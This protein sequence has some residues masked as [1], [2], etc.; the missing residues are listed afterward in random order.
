MLSKKK[1]LTR[2]LELTLLA[3]TA[4][5]NAVSL[6]DLTVESRPGEPMMGTL[7]IRDIDFTVSPLLVR[8]AAP[9]TYLRA[10]LNWPTQVRD[11]R[12]ARD[13]SQSALRIKV[14]GK[15]PMEASSFPLLI[16]MNAGGK[17]SVTNYQIVQKNG[18][19]EVLGWKTIALDNPKTETPFVLTPEVAPAPEAIT[20]QD[21]AKASALATT[22]TPPKVTPSAPED[23]PA[24]ATSTKRYT[25]VFSQKAKNEA[26]VAGKVAEAKAQ[27][28]KTVSKQPK[29]RSAPQIVRDYVALN[30]FDA[31][32]P[33]HVQNNMTLWSVAKLYWPSYRGATLEQL[34]LAFRDRNP[35]AFE[36][37]DP[38]LLNAGSTLT[39]PTVDEVFAIDAMTAFRS[40]HGEN[41]PVPPSTQNL[42]D[43]QKISNTLASTVAD[44]QDRERTDGGAQEAVDQAG[45]EALRNGERA[46]AQ[47]EATLNE[48]V[49][50]AQVVTPEVSAEA[51]DKTTQTASQAPDLTQGSADVAPEEKTQ[52]ATALSSEASSSQELSQD[53]NQNTNPNATQEAE[54]APASPTGDS[55]TAP[56]EDVTSAEGGSTLADAAELSTRSTEANQGDATTSEN[57]SP[58]TAEQGEQ[59]KVSDLSAE[60]TTEL[61]KA[62][63]ETSSSEGTGN[64]SPTQERAP[65]TQEPTSSLSSSAASSDPQK[66]SVKSDEKPRTASVVNESSSEAPS[67]LFWAVG[68][69]L[70]LLLILWFFF[71]RRREEATADDEPKTRGVLSQTTVKPATQAQLT[72]VEKTVDEAVKNGTT[73]GAM[74]VG[75]MAYTEARMKEN[76]AKGQEVTNAQPTS[77]KPS[78]ATA[79]DAKQP[80]L[81]PNDDEL[82]PLETETLSEKEV[83][84]QVAKATSLIADVSLAVE[85]A[86]VVK[87]PAVKEVVV[88]ETVKDAKQRALQQ[89]LEAKYK[90]AQ[91]FVNMGATNEALELLDEVRR[92]GTPEQRGRAADLVAVI[93]AK[94]ADKNA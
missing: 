68:M 12:L 54:L 51:D 11:I 52:D 76:E 82:P 41:T 77:E 26:T 86:D 5:V 40:L 44:A 64:V 55:G 6:G 24:S 27:V 78:V 94:K 59:T 93:E 28:A 56:T 47:T 88:T 85:A 74:G 19:F 17:V 60:P 87:Q 25:Q 22:T 66:S 90:L 9:A 58:S 43:A 36:K 39:P 33:F 70:A 67:G 4:S 79:T 65:V 53:S 42:I 13:D 34:V 16:E 61:N 80:W 49:Q 30:G 75:A 50:P 3:M 8:V 69:A 81:D 45:K 37:S 10:G 57:A 1:L 72:A 83:K 23:K 73:A 62:T 31:A 84:Q 21:A 29:K 35:S 91:S 92:R 18:H 14:Y 7:E 89:A 48:V 15:A 71:T 38:N 32:Q 2:F 46:L 20:T 63:N